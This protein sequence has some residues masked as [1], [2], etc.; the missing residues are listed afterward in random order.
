M[1]PLLLVISILTCSLLSPAHA[2]KVGETVAT[3]LE[4]SATNAKGDHLRGQVN[5]LV[6]LVLAKRL[7]EAERLAEALQ[8]KFEASFNR[9]V[10][11]YSFQSKE[12][13]LEFRGTSPKQFEW[14]DWG[15]KETLQMKAFMAADKQD[16]ASALSILN[17]IEKLAP[18]SAGTAAERGYVLNQLKQFEN[19]LAAYTRAHSLST[20]YPS[21]RPFE[22]ASLRGM[23]FALIEL[24]RL[25]EAEAVF[26][27]SLKIEPNNK[28]ALNELAYIRDLRSKK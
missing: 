6:S 18:V 16:F 4:G 8:G 25:D 10:Q 26:G 12:E 9:R 28:V 23:G 1:K 5:E 21:Q 13:Y 14:I 22:A 11:Q 24:Q 19:A 2:Q 3:P 15:Y 27:D 20:R 17:S 7:T